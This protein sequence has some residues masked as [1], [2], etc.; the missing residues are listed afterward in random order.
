M[1][2]LTLMTMVAT[3]VLIV[4]FAAVFPHAHWGYGVGTSTTLSGPGYCIYSGP[5]PFRLHYK[6]GDTILYRQFLELVF[7]PTVRLAG[8]GL[9]ERLPPAP[10]Y[11]LGVI[12]YLTAGL[13]AGLVVA[14]RGHERVS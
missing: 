11:S 13:I 5:Y 9:F 6:P 14:V 3:G 12:P 7:D 10:L 1:A 8:T 4:Y 2:R